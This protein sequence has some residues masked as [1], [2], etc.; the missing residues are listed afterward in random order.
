MRGCYSAMPD[1]EKEALLAWEKGHVDGSGAFAS[2]DWPGWAKYI[3]PIPDPT[4]DKKSSFAHIYLIRAS[5]GECKIGVSRNAQTRLAQ[6]QTA[7][8]VPLT[9]LHCFPAMN[10]R[11]VEAEL[12]KRFDVKRVR[13]EWFLLSAED[14]AVVCA[15]AAR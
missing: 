3:G 11:G 7:S 15:I 10:A 14:I 6:L 5:T 8:P 1:D 4:P 13:N 12:H 9:L 2:S